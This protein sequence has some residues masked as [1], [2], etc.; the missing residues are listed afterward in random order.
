MSSLPTPSAIRPRPLVGSGKSERRLLGKVVLLDA[1]EPEH[2]LVW[3]RRYAREGADLALCHHLQH[4][5]IAAFQ[6]EAEAAGTRCV[7]YEI[8]LDDEW[9]C[10]LVLESVRECLGSIALIVNKYGD[11]LQAGAALSASELLDHLHAPASARSATTK[12]DL[13]A[14]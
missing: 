4:E 8:L 1:S 14:A 9:N 3:A 10:R 2:G 7:L 11:V 12:K 13:T 6:Q 5:E